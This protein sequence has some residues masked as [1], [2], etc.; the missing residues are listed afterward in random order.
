MF[1]RAQERQ[2]IRS[3]VSH[4]ELAACGRSTLIAT[5]DANKNHNQGSA[6]SKSQFLCSKW[7]FLRPGL[8]TEGRCAQ[9]LSRRAFRPPRSGLVLM[10]PSTAPGLG[11]QGIHNSNASF[12]DHGKSTGEVPEPNFAL[13]NGHGIYRDKYRQSALSCLCLSDAACA[14]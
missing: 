9:G 1:W 5:T 8:R 13:A 11:E 2:A 6:H 12:L 7:P 14:S 3:R 4:A 10:D